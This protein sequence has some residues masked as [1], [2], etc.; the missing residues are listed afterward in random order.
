MSDF[1]EHVAELMAKLGPVEVR[2]MFGGHGLFLD[3]RMFALISGDT[4]YLKTDAENLP[5]FVAEELPPF[6]FRRRDRTVET[7]YRRAPAAALE[8]AELL[9]RWAS[10]AVAA[11]RRAAP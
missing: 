4:L 6:T 9:A 3:Q 7:S 8:D 2:Q 11:A 10:G 5:E 1:A